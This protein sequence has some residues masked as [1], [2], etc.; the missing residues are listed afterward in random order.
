MNPNEF[1]QLLIEPGRLLGLYGDYNAPSSW[2]HGKWLQ[3][4]LNSYLVVERHHHWKKMIGID[5]DTAAI[6]TLVDLLEV[7]VDEGDYSGNQLLLILR[8]PDSSWEDGGIIHVFGIPSDV[9]LGIGPLEVK[10]W[11]PKTLWLSAAAQLKL[12]NAE[13][14]ST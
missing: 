5:W 1:R 4:V 9:Q 7:S 14:N 6:V 10:A 11:R 2:S 8:Y 3:A 12:G 13:D